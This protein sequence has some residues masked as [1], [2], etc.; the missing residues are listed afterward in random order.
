MIPSQQICTI[1]NEPR[2]GLPAMWPKNQARGYEDRG[3]PSL[4]PCLKIGPM[5]KKQLHAEYRTFL[6]GDVH[7]CVAVIVARIGIGPILEK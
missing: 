6:S 3:L 1:L 2:K 5:I 7:W 4:V